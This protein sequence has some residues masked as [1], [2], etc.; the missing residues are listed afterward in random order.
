MITSPLNGGTPRTL[1]EEIASVEESIRNYEYRLQELKYRQWDALILKMLNAFDAKDLETLLSHP[2]GKTFLVKLY[3]EKE[4]A[5]KWVDDHFE[6]WLCPS[7][8]TLMQEQFAE[9]NDTTIT[10]LMP[11]V[12]MFRAAIGTSSVSFTKLGSGAFVNDVTGERVGASGI[13]HGIQ[14]MYNAFPYKRFPRQ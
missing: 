10:V 12:S 6:V 7:P 5:F 8:V 11:H 3:P 13:L 9:I 4:I 1:E 2:I 14:D